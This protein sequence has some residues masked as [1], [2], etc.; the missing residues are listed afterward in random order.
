MNQTSEN[1]EKTN[2]EPEFALFLAPNFFCEFY[3]Y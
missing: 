2:F 3:L 1:G